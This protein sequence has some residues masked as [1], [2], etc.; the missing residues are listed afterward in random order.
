VEFIGER[1]LVLFP[2]GKSGIR[3]GG[4]E[5]EH[6]DTQVLIAEP[7]GICAGVRRAIDIV[8]RALSQFGPPVYVRHEIVHNTHV[9]SEL[10]SRGAIFVDDLSLVPDG[11]VLVLSAHGVS[12]AVRHEAS[13][14][15]RRVFDATCPLVSKIHVEIAKLAKHGYSFLLIGH[16]GHPEVE[17]TM[18]QL[19]DRIRIV[20]SVDDVAKAVV[21]DPDRIAVVT[22]TTMSVDESDEILQA[23]RRRFPKVRE[24]KQADICY[25]TT[26]RQNAVKWLA[27]D[28]NLMLVVG[29]PTSSNSRRLVEVAQR[30]GTPAYLVDNP[31]ELRREWFVG[32]SRVGLSA[33]ASAPDTIVQSVLDSVR[34]FGIRSVRRVPG[35]VETMNFPMVRGLGPP[36]HSTNPPVS[37]ARPMAQD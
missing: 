24:P 13:L 7:H 9:I 29:S 14:R 5:V 3:I 8:E 21:P 36:G 26:N 6:I 18:G 17:G 11:A 37:P 16:T 19:P 25:A 1:R 20:E 30:Q 32:C 31:E 35:V 22:Q 23:I 10:R 34:A 33:G 4:I 2:G 28:V 12:R 15:E 27:P